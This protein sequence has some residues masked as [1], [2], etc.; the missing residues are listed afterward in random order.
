MSEVYEK[1]YEWV[2]SAD[3]SEAVDCGRL[4][5]I[6]NFIKLK[7]GV[8]GRYG[9]LSSRSGR[10]LPLRYEL[11]FQADGTDFRCGREACTPS[12]SEPELGK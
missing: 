7:E 12:R 4:Y 2:D 5:A 11:P 1:G 3:F 9:T 10:E 8:S 6:S